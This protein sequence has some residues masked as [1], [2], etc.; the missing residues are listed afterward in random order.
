MSHLRAWCRI[1]LILA[2]TARFAQ[3]CGILATLAG[4][5]LALSLWRAPTFAPANAAGVLAILLLAVV[6]VAMFYDDSAVPRAAFICAGMAPAA[7]AIAGVLTRKRVRGVLA[8]VLHVA[9]VLAPMIVAILLAW[10]S[11]ASDDAGG[12]DY[13]GY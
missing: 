13:G 10:T 5:G 9:F 11:G 1:L 6:L 7:G 3:V 12:Y 2:H 8:G 4:A